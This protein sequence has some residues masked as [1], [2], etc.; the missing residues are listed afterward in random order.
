MGHLQRDEAGTFARS[1]LPRRQNTPMRPGPPRVSGLHVNG[2]RTLAPSPRTGP[3]RAV[4][5]RQRRCGEVGRACR[6]YARHDGLHLANAYS[7]ANSPGANGE[8]RTAS[9]PAPADRADQSRPGTRQHP[10]PAAHGPWC[11]RPRPADLDSS[12]AAGIRAGHR[13]ALGC[14]AAAGAPARARSTIF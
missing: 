2:A 1:A 11:H 13:R 3:G 14:E 6:Q 8:G 5:E 12:G 4:R 7:P 9:S 10:R